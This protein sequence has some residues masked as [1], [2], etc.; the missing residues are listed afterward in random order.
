MSAHLVQLPLCESSPACPLESCLEFLAGSWRAQIL[1]YLRPEPRTA[2]SLKRDLGGI[3]APRLANLLEELAAR[4][5]AASET[6]ESSERTYRLT[7][8][9]S[10]FQPLL[11]NAATLGTELLRQSN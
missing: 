5:L 9:G 8:L 3:T 6:T 11:E 4:G 7:S 1:W 2:E 10:R